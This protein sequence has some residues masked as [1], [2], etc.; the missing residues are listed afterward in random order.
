MTKWNRRNFIGGGLTALAVAPLMGFRQN[1]VPQL[2]LSL[3]QWALHRSYFGN[4]KEDYANWQRLLATDPDKVLQGPLKPIDFPELAKREFGFDAV[5]YVNTFFYGHAKDARYLK[6]LRKRSD[7]AGV[8]N[9]LI[10]VDEEGL[11]GHPD[12]KER[13]QSIER[14]RKWLEAATMLGCHS[15]RVNAHSIGKKDE[16]HKLAADGLSRLCDLAK[17]LNLGVIIENHGGMSSHPGWLVETIKATGKNNIGTMVDFDNFTYAE[18]K[19]GAVPASTTD[20][21][22]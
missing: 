14:H 21:K 3:S 12:A 10:M 17:P 5:E 8:R 9:L 16:Q 11:L 7:G 6:E 22:G 20:T 2:K 18:D 15:V 4:S 19:I 13:A 1:K